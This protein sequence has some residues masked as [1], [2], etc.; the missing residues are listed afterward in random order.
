MYPRH[1]RL[2]QSWQLVLN[3]AAQ[4]AEALLTQETRNGDTTF[5]FLG[6]DVAVGLVFNG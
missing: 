2:C 1:I 6:V 4:A 5:D 3:E